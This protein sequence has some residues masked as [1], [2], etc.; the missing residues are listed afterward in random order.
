MFVTGFADVFRL[1]Q[2]IADLSHQVATA[3]PQV[4][5]RIADQGRTTGSSELLRHAAGAGTFDLPRDDDMLSAVLLAAAL[6]DDDHRAFTV[7][8]ALLLLDRLKNGGGRDD[9]YWNWD[10]FADHYRL[11][12]PAMRAAIMC[13]FRALT[14][15]RGL[16]LSHPPT[17]EDCLTE[18]GFATDL[19]PSPEEAARLWRARVAQTAPLTADERRLFRHF[20]ER[21]A[22]MAPEYPDS[23]PPVPP[24]T[25]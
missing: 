23:C 4:L 14:F 8:T 9:L 24:A 3:S 25:D 1:R 17:P 22:G 11:A 10:A 12:A 5:A 20:V 2:A 13:G 18:P 19:D 21:E 16:Y 6:P 7:A 15:A